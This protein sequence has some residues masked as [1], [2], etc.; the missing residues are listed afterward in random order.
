MFFLKINL[1]KKLKFFFFFFFLKKKKKRML[2]S[3]MQRIRTIVIRTPVTQK[4]WTVWTLPPNNSDFQFKDLFVDIG[5]I[6]K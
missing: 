6:E 1:L 2:V 3:P 5:Y 4:E